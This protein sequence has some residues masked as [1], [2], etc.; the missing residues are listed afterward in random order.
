VKPPPFSRDTC[1]ALRL[2]ILLIAW[3]GNI[4]WWTRIVKQITV[5]PMPMPSRYPT[6]IGINISNGSEYDLLDFSIQPLQIKTLT[7]PSNLNTSGGL[8]YYQ[9]DTALVHESLT[10]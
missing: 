10:K 8:E 4:I 6:G 3:I 7:W 5:D 1:T 9:F 2:V